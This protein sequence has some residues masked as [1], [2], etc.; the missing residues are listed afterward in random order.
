[1]KTW[2]VIEF[3]LPFPPSANHYWRATARGGYLTQ[4]AKNYHSAV[5]AV[6]MQNRLKKNL[7]GRLRVELYVH[8]PDRRQ[9][10]IANS[11]KVLCDSLQ[12]SQVY[13]NDTQIDQLYIER[14]EIKK[15]GA[16]RVRILE[17]EDVNEG[18]IC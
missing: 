4:K 11:E 17:L 12:K 18:G 9:R 5:L 3:W 14:C 10:D 6:V 15:D 7:T 16:V 8:P 1:M 13:E 2:S